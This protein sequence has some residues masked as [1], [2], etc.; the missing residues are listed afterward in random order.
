VLYNYLRYISNLEQNPRNDPKVVTEIK[1]RWR[2][3]MVKH[4]RWFIMGFSDNP[5]LLEEV[6][7]EVAVMLYR[8]EHPS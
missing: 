1:R 2:R 4:P 3:E 7:R 5:Q 8:L 6:K